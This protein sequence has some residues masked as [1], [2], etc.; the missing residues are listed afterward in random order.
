MR[1]ATGLVLAII[2]FML[3]N[4]FRYE[5]WQMG[6]FKNTRDNTCENQFLKEKIKV[7]IK[8]LSELHAMGVWYKNE[9]KIVFDTNVKDID[10]VSHEV[11]HMTR[12][13]TKRHRLIG[14]E[15]QAF[16]QGSF[17]QCVYELINT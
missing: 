14:E 8:D 12:T 1:I 16:M 7:E 3:I 5:D 6:A 13:L 11:Y 4:P 10:T 15:L 2:I 9:N 17:T